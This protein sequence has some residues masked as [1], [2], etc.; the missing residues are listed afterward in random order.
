[1]HLL[2]FLDFFFLLEIILYLILLL[3]QIMGYG[4]HLGEVQGLEY[5]YQDLTTVFLHWVWTAG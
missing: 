5:K 4:H 1:M 3:S 2:S